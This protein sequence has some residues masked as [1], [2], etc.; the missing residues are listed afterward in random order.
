[1]KKIYFLFIVSV[2]LCACNMQTE[3]KEIDTSNFAF[4]EVAIA[5]EGMTCEG[6]ENTV[7]T[8][9]LKLQGVGEVKASH[10]NKTVTVMVDTSFTQLDQI[11][12]SIDKV[13]YTVIK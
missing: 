3:P 6:C 9:L 11:E 1:M 12:H 4:I 13:G 2:L 5:V 10:I 7:Q 8:E